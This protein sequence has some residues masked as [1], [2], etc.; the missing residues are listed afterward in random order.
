VVC[1][2]FPEWEVVLGRQVEKGARSVSKT[3]DWEE[4]A[5]ALANMAPGL[6]AEL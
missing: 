4:L 1:G 6:L 3:W 2:V 5:T